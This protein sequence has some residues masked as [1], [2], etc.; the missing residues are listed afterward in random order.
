MQRLGALGTHQLQEQMARERMLG[1]PS[2][3]PSGFPG[4]AASAAAAQSALLLDQHRQINALQEAERM[5]QAGQIPG[6]GL[7]GGASALSDPALISR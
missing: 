3:S 5:R 7:P 6:L 4:G 2:P 1:V